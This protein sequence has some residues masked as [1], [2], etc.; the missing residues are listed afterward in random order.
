MSSF[1]KQ[2]VTLSFA[3]LASVAFAQE[4]KAEPAASKTTTPP[5]AVFTWGGDVRV[6]YE[7]YDSAQ[8]LN[9]DAPFH[10]RDYYRVRTRAWANIVPFK[11]AA[12]SVRLAAEPRYWYNNS[13]VAGEGKEWK[14][15][16][17]DNLNAKW[18]SPSAGSVP[19]T[20]VVGRQDIQ[21]GDQWLVGD[22]TPVDGSWTTFFDGARATLDLKGLKT[23]V[24][25]IGFD[26]QAHPKDHFPILGRQAAY[27]LMEQDEKGAVVYAS[28][29]SIKNTQI[30]GYFIYKRDSKVT[31]SGNNGEAYTAGARVAGT[32]SPKWQYSSEVAYQ[33]GRRDLALRYPTTQAARMR[34]IEASGSISKLTYLF[35]D[36]LNNQISVLAEY[37]SG[38]DKDTTGTD[39]MFDVLW[40]RYPRVGETWAVAYSAETSSRNAQYQN[41]SRIGATWTISPIKDGSIATSYFAMFAP[42]NVPTRAATANLFSRDGHFRAHTVQV[43]AKQKINKWLNALLFAEASFLGDYY[44]HHDRITF[45]RAEL[46]ATF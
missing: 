25:V 28:N 29:K 14:Y 44:T 12:I 2:T 13:S 27:T 32:I 11:D 39:E 6:R 43:V 38:D 26:Q 20:V 7:A 9:E 33:W 41:M 42:E 35:K 17:V 4:K 23:K 19:V 10:I 24:D 15:A 34:T 18:S 31:S 3:L 30:D 16:I 40:G 36:K 22:G 8:T 21:L 1:R 5:P 46:L 45:V 37:L